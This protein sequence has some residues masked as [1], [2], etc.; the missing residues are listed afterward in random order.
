MKVGFIIICYLITS[1]TFSYTE[2]DLLKKS[3]LDLPIQKETSFGHFKIEKINSIKFSE[4]EQRIIIN[5]DAKLA[6]IKFD[7]F[8]IS[9]KPIF[10]DKKLFLTEI[11]AE[12]IEY[13]F[14]IKTAAD[15]IIKNYI[16]KVEILEI[17]YFEKILLKSFYI[18]AEG[19]ELKINI[20]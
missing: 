11:K 9:G 7:Y 10:I 12:Q 19:I 20:F 14:S 1:C 18:N 17:S 13:L 16:S 4:D 6:K 3:S 15:F 5:M 8:I 2:K